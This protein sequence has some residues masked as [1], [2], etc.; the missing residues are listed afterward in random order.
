MDI[1]LVRIDDRLIHGQVATVWAK[2]LDIQRIL[3][4]SDAVT[5]DHLRKMLLQQ[6]APPGVKVNVITV[7]KMI[8]VYSHE[9]FEGLRVILLFTNPLEVAAVVEAG[10][11]L[12]SINIGAMGYSVGKKMISNTIAV[13]EQDVEAFRYLHRRGIELEIRKVIT[14]NKQLL[15]DVLKKSNIQ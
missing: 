14:D 2:R 4:V 5:K 8:E 7:S 11:P 10:V 1:R 15:W 9:L 6:A 3:V 12:S 13:N